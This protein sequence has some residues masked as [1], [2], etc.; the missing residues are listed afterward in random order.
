M[1]AVRRGGRGGR[2]KI[3]GVRFE[4]PPLSESPDLNDDED[5]AAQLRQTLEHLMSTIESPE[6]SMSVVTG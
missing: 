5:L 1:T 4:L 3:R 2:G 6:D